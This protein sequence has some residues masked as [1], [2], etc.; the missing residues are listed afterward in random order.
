[1]ICIQKVRQKNRATQGAPC[2]KLTAAGKALLVPG[3]P[4]KQTPLQR[5]QRVYRWRTPPQQLRSGK[6]CQS[7][8][9]KKTCSKSAKV[10]AGR[11]VHPKCTALFKK[12]T[13]ASA[14]SGTQV[15]VAAE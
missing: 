6:Y 14:G 3:A 10:F 8:L 1:M 7:T 15:P 2:F 4:R 5:L 12:Q 13:P 9:I 11:A